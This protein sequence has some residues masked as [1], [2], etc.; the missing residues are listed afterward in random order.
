MKKNILLLISLLLL[1]ALLSACG[2]QHIWMDA[3]CEAPKTCSDCGAAEGAAL[4]H[5]WLD[6]SCQTPKTCSN[7]GMTQGS[8]LYH[9][10]QDATCLAPKTCA[11]CGATEGSKLSHDYAPWKEAQQDSSGRWFFSRSCIF[12]GDTQTEETDGPGTRKNTAPPCI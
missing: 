8:A 1:C 6:A 5:S 11:D 3:S 7:C 12:C 10:W 9:K 4:G 2:H